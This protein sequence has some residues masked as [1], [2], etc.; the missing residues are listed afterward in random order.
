MKKNWLWLLGLLLLTGCAATPV[1]IDVYKPLAA[2]AR[3]EV[4]TRAGYSF[5][6]YAD[7]K[8]RVGAT[9]AGTQNVFVV[10]LKVTNLT[11]ADLGPDD[12]AIALTDGRDA[13]PLTLLTRESVIKYRASL[14]GGTDLKSGNPMADLALGQLNNVFSALSEPEK[15]QV[16]R[17]VDWAIEHYFSFRPIYAGESREGVLCYYPGFVL[18]YPLTLKV[19]LKDDAVDLKFWPP[20]D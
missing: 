13:K 18:E 3:E 10:S 16:V 1:K 12:Y 17:S 20:K 8:Y 7:Q 4:T 11:G 14:T 5:I 9:L 6:E 15:N 19:K 2:S